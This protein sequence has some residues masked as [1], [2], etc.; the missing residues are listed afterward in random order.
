[1]KRP[2]IKGV[3]VGELLDLRSSDAGTGLL[4]GYASKFWVVDSYGE[5]VAPGAFQTSIQERGP[6][7]ADRI[8]LRY[9][10]DVTVG[11]AT[12]LSEDADGLVV[13][14]KV[15]D[16]GKDGTALRRQLA[17]GVPYGLSIGFYR[18]QTRPATEDD[19]LNFDYA[20]A[21]IKQFIAADGPG[22]VTVHTDMKLVEFSAVSFP[23][24]DNALVEGFRAEQISSLLTD[25]KAGRLTEGERLVLQELTDAWL[26]DV[27]KGTGETPNLTP[28]PQTV[29]RNFRAEAALIFAE[30]REMGIVV[31]GVHA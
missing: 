21:W 20:P 2:M 16:D 23:A 27:G 4:S 29:T 25:L 13:E 7:G 18:K 22:A 6:D 12:K 30:M 3:E 19:P 15:S 14:A 10:H 17:D 1:M 28:E 9:E 26:A 31:D 5:A 11:K 8:L 24:V